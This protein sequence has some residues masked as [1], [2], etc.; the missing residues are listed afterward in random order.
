MQRS[1]ETLS[2]CMQHNQPNWS[3]RIRQTTQVV[4]IFS[5]RK[6]S[7]WLD[8]LPSG[9][10]ETWDQLKREFFDKYFPTAKYLAWKKDISSFKQQEGEVLYDAWERFKLLLKRC[11][12]H[13]PSKMDIMQAFTT[14][15]NPDTRMLLDA[16]T[17]GTMKINT[18]YEV[19][20]LIDNMSLNEYRGHIEEEATP[21]KKD[22]IDLNTQDALLS[23][24]KLLYIQLETIAKRLEAREVAHLSAQANCEICEQAHENGACLPTS[25]G[26]SEEQVK[27]M[28]NYP[29]SRG[30]PI[31][32]LTIQVGQNIQTSHIEVTMFYNHRRQ[33]APK[34]TQKQ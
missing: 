5:N 19:R 25:L 26:F 17:G 2:G 3:I 32:T 12:G 15:L 29:G 16:S 33:T 27:Y 23:S 8:A 28:G 20:K 4:W 10:I 1:F 30:I 9:S 7:D 13:K 11:P 34:G 24:N 6:A 14:R 31:P 18:V 22:M 21:R